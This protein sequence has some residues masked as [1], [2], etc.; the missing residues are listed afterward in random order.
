MEDGV[1]EP[2]IALSPQISHGL[3]WALN[4]YQL[5]GR[6]TTGQKIKI[7]AFWHNILVEIYSAFRKNSIQ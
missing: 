7:A 2:S 6:E 5:C 3:M 1:I 4:T